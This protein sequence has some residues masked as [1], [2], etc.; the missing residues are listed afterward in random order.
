MSIFKKSPDREPV[1]NNPTFNDF[2][3]VADNCRGY[4][5]D[6]LNMGNN[7]VSRRRALRR[8]LRGLNS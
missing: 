3:N 1:P 5:N 2:N 6:V 8:K 7:P 4:C